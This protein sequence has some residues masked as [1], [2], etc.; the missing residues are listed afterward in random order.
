MDQVKHEDMEAATTTGQHVYSLL[1]D[2]LLAANRD[3]SNMDTDMHLED[4]GTPIEE[5]P[6]YAAYPATW[7]GYS[8]SV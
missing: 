8:P 4:K 1:G 6:W 2:T 7:L 5:E 3:E